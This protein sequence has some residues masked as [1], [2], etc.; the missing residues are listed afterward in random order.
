MVTRV[1]VGAVLSQNTAECGTLVY[2]WVFT[3]REVCL[4]VKT[5]AIQLHFSD[6][7]VPLLV[8]PPRAGLALSVCTDEGAALQ[9][10]KVSG[11]AA[12]LKALG[13]YLIALA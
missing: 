7:G 8:A 2:D 13:A 5:A 12:G 1:L 3:H 9:Q 11:N 6:A 10:V 4:I